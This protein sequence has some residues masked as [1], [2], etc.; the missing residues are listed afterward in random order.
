[1]VNTSSQ[2]A[3]NPYQYHTVGDGDVR[4]LPSATACFLLEMAVQT[5]ITA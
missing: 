5:I 3:N 2:A 4:R 1:M